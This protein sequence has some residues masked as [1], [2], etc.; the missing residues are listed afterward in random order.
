VGFQCG[1]KASILSRL[2]LFNKLLTIYG[3][4]TNVCHLTMIL[5][6]SKLQYEAEISGQKLVFN[7]PLPHLHVHLSHKNS[8]GPYYVSV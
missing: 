1:C 8:L 2:T 6:I 5:S 7:Q 4:W 3:I